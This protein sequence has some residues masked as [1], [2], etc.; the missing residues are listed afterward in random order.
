MKIGIY[1]GTFD[2]PH[3][4]HLIV[5]E[6]VRVHQGLD[7]VVFIPVAMAP[8]K[9]GQQVTEARHRLAMLSL[10]VATNPAFVVSD[11][12]IR[13]GGV[14]YTVDTLAALRAMDPAADL[15]ILIGADNARD[16]DSWKDPAAI[17]AA[18]RIVVM[19]RPR[20]ELDLGE[21]KKKIPEAV[22]VDV[23]GIDIAGR[24]IR[25]RIAAG[26][27]VKYL[28]PDGVLDYI[29]QNSLYR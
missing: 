22:V 16:F 13:R 11:E 26:L 21:L 27:S 15:S 9:Q 25:R 19:H 7:R 8:H 20:V 18:A 23:P 10:A 4:G 14:S 3:L 29:L 24:V 17:R 1:G 6:H 12:E 28:V 5:A 2:P